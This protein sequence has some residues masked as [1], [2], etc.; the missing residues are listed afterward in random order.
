M[1]PLISLIAAVARNG[2]IGRQGGLPWRLRDDMTFFAETTMGKPV[3][4]GRKTY[5]SI[6]AKFR[7]LVGRRN[8]VI[9]RDEHWAEQGVK[10]AGN[11]ADAVYLA[12]D[13]EEIMVAGGG[14]IY[15]QALPLANR[16]YVTE[17]AAEVEGDVVFPAFDK[18]VWR[19]VSRQEHQEGEHSYAWVVYERA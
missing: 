18:A 14:E 16:L 11:L 13:A 1:A 7:P 4:M 6:P 2:V 17:I 19:E 3:I 5:E 9:T 12:G 8:I 15:A 10:V